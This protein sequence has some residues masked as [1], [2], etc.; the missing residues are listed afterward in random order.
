MIY[1]AHANWT[2]EDINYETERKA[3][4]LCADSYS[5]A[6]EKLTEFYGENEMT[7]VSL[8]PFLPDDF[9]E[10]DKDTLEELELFTE[11]KRTIGEKV[12]W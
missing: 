12:I 3:L 10:F 7:Y 4:F 8:E 6:I 9:L 5:D 1:I 11:I 2:S